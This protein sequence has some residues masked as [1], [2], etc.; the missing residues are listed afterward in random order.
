MSSGASICCNASGHVH[1]RNLGQEQAANCS[2]PRPHHFGIKPLHLC[3]DERHV[4]ALGDQSLWHPDFVKEL[5]AGRWK[6]YMTFQYPAIGGPS[7]KACTSCRRAYYFVYRDGE[8][9]IHRCHDENLES[10]RSFVGLVKPSTIR[11]AVPS[12]PIR[13]PTWRWD[14]S[15]PAAWTPAITSQPWPALNTPH[16]IGFGGHH[17][18][19]AAGR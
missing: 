12:K 15:C 4:H 18:A 8:M 10:D 9:S 2:A 3:Q 5:N 14:P 16:S 13:L 7:S 17:N 1:L 6:P 19:I 11:Y